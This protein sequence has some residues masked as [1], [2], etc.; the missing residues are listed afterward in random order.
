MKLI[1]F[2]GV[3]FKVADEAFLVRQIRQLFE[4]D[5]TKKKEAFWQQISY[6]WFMC[7][8]RSTYMYL[9]DEDARAEEVKAQEGF[10]KDWQPSDLLKQAMEV[11]TKQCTTTASLLL[12]DMRY[13]IDTVRKIIR[14]I[15]DAIDPTD[16]S[17]K[18]S[19][20]LDKALPA[21]T[22][23]L[24]DIPELAKKLADAEQA[25]AKDFDTSDVARG[26]AQKSA[27]EDEI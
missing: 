14:K 12:Q 9:T 25:L 21:M 17:G 11:Y 13:G 8:P 4:A 23:T 1:E 3:E 26:A 27:F 20:A 5:K 24:N 2:D 10:G 15:G 18:T 19:M 16:D 7:D 6:L 22:K